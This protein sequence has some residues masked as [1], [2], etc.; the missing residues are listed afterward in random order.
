[1]SFR[2]VEGIAFAHQLPVSTGIRAVER[3]R[4]ATGKVPEATFLVHLIICFGSRFPNM[5]EMQKLEGDGTR[6]SNP[7][8]VYA[9]VLPGAVG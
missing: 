7:V 1:M 3:E 8:G 5:W 4:Q 9:V 2:C 6:T